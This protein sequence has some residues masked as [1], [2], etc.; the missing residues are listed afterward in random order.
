MEEVQENNDFV[1]D[2][3]DEV[4]IDDEFEGIEVEEDFEEDNDIGFK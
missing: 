1:E 2:K 4:D 3:E